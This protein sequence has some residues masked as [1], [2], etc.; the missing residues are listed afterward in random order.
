MD[1]SVEFFNTFK[2]GWHIVYIGGSQVIISI[3]TY[4]FAN[5]A[6]PVEISHFCVISPRFK[7][8][9]KVPV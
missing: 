7:L 1:F 3:K 9:A 4:C 2:S 6:D 8:S 5:S